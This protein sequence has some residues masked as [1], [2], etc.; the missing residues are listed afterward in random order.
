M[1]SVKP[2][3]GARLARFNAQKKNPSFFSV[4]WPLRILS[5]FWR[6]ARVAEDKMWAACHDYN[7]RRR[8]GAYWKYFGRLCEARIVLRVC[9]VFGPARL[10]GL[11]F[12]VHGS[13]VLC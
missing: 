3:S 6:P 4:F 13:V 5:H 1:N 8:G 10:G 7:K 11:R 12:R 2:S 9:F